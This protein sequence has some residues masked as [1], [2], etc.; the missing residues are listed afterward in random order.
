MNI[1]SRRRAHT[2]SQI[3]AWSQATAH[4]DI[5]TDVED[6]FAG[7]GAVEQ[8]GQGCR[9]IENRTALDVNEVGDLAV[10]QMEKT[11]PATFKSSLPQTI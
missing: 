9:E 8:A 6:L 11:V 7:V 4:R 10:S 1:P 5:T 2:R 3:A